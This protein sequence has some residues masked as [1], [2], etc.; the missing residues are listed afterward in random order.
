MADTLTK[1]ES[2]LKDVNPNDKIRLL[3]MHS[4]IKL[5]KL[6]TEATKNKEKT[7]A[8]VKLNKDL[9]NNFLRKMQLKADLEERMEIMAMM[10][11]LMDKTIS[12]EEKSRFL[13]GSRVSSPVVKMFKE[14]FINNLKKQVEKLEIVKIIQDVFNYIAKERGILGGYLLPPSFIVKSVNETIAKGVKTISNN[15]DT[16]KN[17][18]KN[19]NY[20]N[21]LLKKEQLS[22]KEIQVANKGVKKVEERIKETNKIGNKREVI[23]IKKNWI[24]EINKQKANRK[25]INQEI[26]R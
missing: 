24:E 8:V 21:D 13:N 7:L 26:G 18:V 2:E 22:S 1:L 12:H 25:T 16:A 11:L 15:V 23:Q 17:I 6:W 3:K 10:C 14:C 19:I 5:C 20:K 9:L 4:Q